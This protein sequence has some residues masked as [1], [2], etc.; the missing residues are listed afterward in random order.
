M[1][2]TAS[3]PAPHQLAA[4]RAGTLTTGRCA[5]SLEGSWDVVRDRYPRGASMTL[6]WAVASSS[7]GRTSSE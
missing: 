6:E 5:L 4:Q 1:R 7:G 3:T 2:E